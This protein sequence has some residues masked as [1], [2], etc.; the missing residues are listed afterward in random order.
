ME[1]PDILAN[2]RLG[3][4][5]RT[6][7]PGATT[8]TLVPREDHFVTFLERAIAPTEITQPCFAGQHTVFIRGPELPA[9]ATK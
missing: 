3:K 2:A 8:S 4:Q 6:L 7:S 1:V 9:A 5:L